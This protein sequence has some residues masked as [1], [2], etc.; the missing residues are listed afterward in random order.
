MFRESRVSPAAHQLYRELI[1]GFLATGNVQGSGNIDLLREL[2][3]EDWLALDEDGRVMVLYPF[4][5]TPTGI[6]VT[7]DGTERQAMCA[8]DALGIAAMLDAEVRVRTT[9]SLSGAPLQIGIDA[10]GSVSSTPDG[11]V[12]LRRRQGGAAHLSRCAA[13][14]FFRSAAD[15][16]QW[17]AGDGED[18]DE[19]LSLAEAYREA[20]VI[21]GR[22]YRDG[23]RLVI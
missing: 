21:F 23:V 6:E 13:T 5:L 14:R 15:A 12:V 9:C 11:A 3:G 18:G 22:A 2:A 10:S 4:S 8:I 7:V 16:E 17:H 19:V 20:S 1:D